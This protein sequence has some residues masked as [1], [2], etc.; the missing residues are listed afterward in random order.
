M[1]MAYK[2]ITRRRGA[3]EVSDANNSVCVAT[4]AE[5]E[6]VVAIWMPDHWHPPT[7]NGRSVEEWSDVLAAYSDESPT[8]SVCTDDEG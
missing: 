2:E 5:A 3:Y 6:A 7:R 1:A 8:V 4:L